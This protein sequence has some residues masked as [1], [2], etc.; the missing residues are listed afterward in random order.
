MIPCFAYYSIEQTILYEGGNLV[1][2][3]GDAD[4]SSDYAA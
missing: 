2:R 1:L 4:F 3:V